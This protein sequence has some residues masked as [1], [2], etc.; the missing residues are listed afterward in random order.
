MEGSRQ[1]HELAQEGALSRAGEGG[2]HALVTLEGAH[3]GTDVAGGEAAEAGTEQVAPTEKRRRLE[4]REAIA[5]WGWGE[6]EGE[7]V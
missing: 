3:G 6:G 1:A 4:S 7:G 5:T 2:V